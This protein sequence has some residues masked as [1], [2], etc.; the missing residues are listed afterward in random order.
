MLQNT[1]FSGIYTITNL[2]NNKIYVGFAIN[3]DKRKWQHFDKLKNKEHKNVYLQSSFDKYGESNFK[4]EILEEC[5]T[6]FLASQENYWCNLLNTHNDKYGYNIRPTHP[7]G[8]STNNKFIRDKISIK[9]KGRKQTKETTSKIRASRRRNGH[10]S[11]SEEHKFKI[12]S[13]NRVKMLGKKFSNET[14]SKM[15]ASFKGRK[16]S[17]SFKENLRIKNTGKKLSPETRQ[18]ISLSRIGVRKVCNHIPVILIDDVNNTRTKFD[19][20]TD[21]AR[22]LKCSTTAISQ[23]TLG[24]RKELKGFKIVKDTHDL[25]GTRR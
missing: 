19:C 25:Q 3:F 15:S 18:K 24:R 20:V 22:Y 5:S 16:M 9:N 10:A 2:V 21:L 4:F 13:A 1:T 12:G 14:R 6:D 17:E 7:N 11:L 8:K 23:V